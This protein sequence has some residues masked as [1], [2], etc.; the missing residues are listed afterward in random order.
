M[1]L[2]S[3]TNTHHDVT[4]LVNY[5]IVKN[6]KTWISREQNITLLWNKNILNLCLRWHILRS[7][8][9]TAEVTFKLLIK[10][11]FIYNLTVHAELSFAASFILLV[12]NKWNKLSTILLRDNVAKAM[13][14][15]MNIRP[16]VYSY[17]CTPLLLL[18][19]S[20]TLANAAL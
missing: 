1:H 15:S 11:L 10:S 14:C 5:R 3:C 7:Y 2:V 18:A 20:P 13:A 6:T 4:D 9:F 19:F 12:S 16:M 8:S 17:F